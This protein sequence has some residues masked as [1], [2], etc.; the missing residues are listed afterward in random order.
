[1]K[2]LSDRSRQRRRSCFCNTYERNPFLFVSGQGVYLRDEN[3]HDYLDLL[4][5]IGVSA[6]GYAHPAIEE[7]IAAQSKQPHPHLEPLLP[8]AHRRTRPPPHR[9]QRPRPRLLLQQRHRSLGGR[10]EARPRPRRSAPRRRPHHRHEV[11]RPRTQLPRP[12]HGLRRHHAQGEVPRALRARH[13]RRRVRPLQR[14]RRSAREVLRTK[15]APSASSPSRAKAAS[16]PS[17]QEF[18][19]AAR[20]LCDSTGALLLADEI[21]SG[22]GRTGKWFAYQH[23]GILPDVTTLAKPIANGIPMGAMLCTEEAA[24]AIH[25]RHARHHLRRRS[26]RLRRRH[27][28]H[29]HHQARQPPRPH[30][31]SRRLL[32]RSNSHALATRHDCI[33]DVRGIGLMLG[34]ELNS[35]DLAKQ[36]RRR[37]DGA[38][39]HHQ[40]HQ[41]DRPS[42]PSA[43]HP[44]A[45]ARR[46]SHHSARRDLVSCSIRRRSAGRRTIPWVAKP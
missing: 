28:R 38:P 43:L 18:F 3:G 23:Y 34:L 41:R 1:M 13:A 15:S 29:R 10:T 14:R 2:N 9:D 26:T 17:R 35:A 12:H 20:E 31:R 39:H 19:A 22:M 25:S 4:S 21:Q 36:R 16:I 37:A 40:P 5:G 42:L 32:P 30:P 24:D 33:V 11:P 6:L 44:R 7:A 45:Q 46:D 27:R 8:R